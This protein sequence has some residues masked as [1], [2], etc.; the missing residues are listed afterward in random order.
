MDGRDMTFPSYDNF[1]YFFIAGAAQGFFL[2]ICLFR[3]KGNASKVFALIVFFISYDLTAEYLFRMLGWDD[4][5]KVVY[6][7]ETSEFFYYVT[8]SVKK[9]F[10]F[11]Y[12]PLTFVYVSIL[13]GRTSR[14]RR[15]D[16]LHFMP[17]IGFLCLDILA[18][19]PYVYYGSD[20]LYMSDERGIT[21]YNIISHTLRFAVTFSYLCASLVVIVAY[22]KKIRHFYS[23]LTK[24]NLNWLAVF[25]SFSCVIWMVGGC[26]TFLYIVHSVYAENVS[27]MVFTISSIAIY[28]T[29][30][31]ALLQSDMYATI[32]TMG[33][34]SLS[35]NDEGSE[36]ITKKYR[37][38]F[39]PEDQ[40]K[41]YLDT[42]IKYMEKERPYLDPDFSLR[43]FSTHV[44]IKPHYVSQV[45][46]DCIGKNFFNLVN[47]YRVEYAK[48]M[49]ASSGPDGN[50][51]SICYQAGFNSKSVFNTV[52]R[53]KYGITPSAFREGL[54]ER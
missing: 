44:G 41:K 37:K 46:N 29:G 13:T 50:I 6:T 45:I 51:L 9:L 23:N 31:F 35:K 47:E 33:D 21:G 54:G 49:I 26:S 11:M 52:F 42:I 16:L 15:G 43:D 8:Y 20:L 38:N 3:K 24:I 48:E 5:F 34:M 10:G 2:A 40:K 14:F 12:G 19:I 25:I 7:K 22:R 18:R 39:I 53:N 36:I 28:C 27:F 30:Y 17:A 32:H 4:M 1:Y